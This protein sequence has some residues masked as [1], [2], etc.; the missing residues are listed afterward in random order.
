MLKKEDISNIIKVGLILFA[1][2]AVS[3][4]VLA[5]VNAATA[6]VIAKNNEEKQAMR[7][8]IEELSG[9]CNFVRSY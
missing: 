2:T 5:V 9:K 7:V 3:A 4:F 8:L 6:P 1:I